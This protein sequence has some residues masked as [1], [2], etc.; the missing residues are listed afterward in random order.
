MRLDQVKQFDE[1]HFQNCSNNKAATR[2]MNSSNLCPLAVGLSRWPADVHKVNIK[3]RMLPFQ[4]QSPHGL[5][6]CS[7]NQSCYVQRSGRRRGSSAKRWR[8]RRVPTEQLQKWQ[9]F[10]TT[11]WS[12]STCR[13]ESSALCME[14]QLELCYPTKL[15]PSLA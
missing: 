3:L 5:P 9:T 7:A 14:H 6:S 2:R 11:P 4:V 12:F 10:C 8:K 1:H 15:K 13:Y